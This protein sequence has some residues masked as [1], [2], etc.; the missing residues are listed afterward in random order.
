MSLYSTWDIALSHL[1]IHS[2]ERGLRGEVIRDVHDYGKE[3]CLHFLCQK[4]KT[5]DSRL[6]KLFNWY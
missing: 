3:N 1:L 4:K 5:V 6:P 2:H